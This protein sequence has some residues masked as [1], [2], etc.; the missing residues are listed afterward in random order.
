MRIRAFGVGLM[1]VAASALT[2]AAV[3]GLIVKRQAKEGQTNS[4]RL[5]AQFELQGIEATY[6]A[7][8]TEKI[9]KVDTDGTITL[10]ASQ[11]DGKATFNGQDVD[12]GKNPQKPY[13]VVYN[14]D[15]TMKEISGFG[16]LSS[17]GANDPNTTQNA[18]RFENL[19][20][21]VDPGHPVNVGDTWTYEVK[22]DAKL[23]TV[24]A[25]A[26][27]KV[28][29]E[30]KVGSVDAIKIHAVVKETGGESAAS[31]DSMVWLDKTDGSVVKKESKLVNAPFP[32]SPAPV[33][34]T[35]SE[36]RE[37]PAK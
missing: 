2:F 25:K 36:L 17:S 21:V 11:M 15:G 27:Y 22:P 10:E 28:L 13:T 14:A 34:G 1:M 26:E 37:T 30:E 5:K 31:M 23:G 33:S 6:T 7:L 20:M 18:Y 29:A 24:A 3:D 8:A 35:I 12:L 4:L 16:D 9:T 32:G 19:D